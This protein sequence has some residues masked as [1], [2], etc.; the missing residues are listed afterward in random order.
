MD[1]GDLPTIVAPNNPFAGLS[2]E[3]CLIQRDRHSDC[4]FPVCVWRG[5]KSLERF[6]EEE[7]DNVGSSNRPGF[8]EHT[9]KIFER[10]FRIESL[11]EMVD[12]V[13][14][15]DCNWDEGG[16]SKLCDLVDLTRGAACE[17]RRECHDYLVRHDLP[18]KLH[19]Q[20]KKRIKE[21]SRRRRSIVDPV[22]YQ[23]ISS[24]KRLADEN[25]DTR[26][27][28]FTNSANI[29]GWSFS[30]EFDNIETLLHDY[31]GKFEK[32]ITP[33]CKQRLRQLSQ[34]IDHLQLCAGKWEFEPDQPV[35]KASPT[36]EEGEKVFCWRTRFDFPNQFT[37]VQTQ[38][39]LD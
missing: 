18:I 16:I 12:K 9:Q 24:L 29:H 19:E 28:L 38:V 15:K 13:S 3:A 26:M 32:Q 22:L 27:Q 2:A 23:L 4:T 1:S 14:Y 35:D 6:E 5:S 17:H 33:G 20:E 36:A 34:T 10:A 37:R 39:I 8:T 31:L 7:D 11:L 30:P 21:I 25:E